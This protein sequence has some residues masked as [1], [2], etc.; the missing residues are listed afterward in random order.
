M[1][2]KTDTGLVNAIIANFGKDRNALLEAL[3]KIHS[4][5]GYESLD[6]RSLADEISAYVMEQVLTGQD[7]AR[8][9]SEAGFDN[10][11]IKLFEN[12][13]QRQQQP[14]FGINRYR[15]GNALFRTDAEGDGTE[16]VG[17]VQGA[18]EQESD[19]Y[20]PRTDDESRAD[21][22]AQGS[23]GQL[24]ISEDASSPIR[25]STSAAIEGA[26][27]KYVQQDENGDF[28]IVFPDGRKMT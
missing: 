16:N 6:A 3:G 26:G 9:L 4:T 17:D 15:N 25:F 24:E 28:A 21:A 27:L 13:Q 11:F 18:A 22:V 19:G 1:I 8:M 10:N 2:N 20:L 14:G 23:G 7:Y 5:L 12:E